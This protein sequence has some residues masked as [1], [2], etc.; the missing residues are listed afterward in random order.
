MTVSWGDLASG[1]RFTGSLRSFLRDR[2]TPQEARRILAQRL[3]DREARFLA[4]LRTIYG[5]AASPYRWLLQVAGCEYGDLVGLVGDQGVEGALQELYRR[6]V[7]LTVAEFKGR[8]PAVRGSAMLL[9]DSALLHRPSSKFH[10]PL[11][12]GGSR[13]DPTTIRLDLASARQAAVN[14][15]LEFE[16]HGG[17]AWPKGS[18]ILPGSASIFTLLSHS[19]FGSVAE[20]WFTPVDVADPALHPRYRWSARALRWGSLAAGIALPLPAFVSLDHPLPI[21]RWLQALLRSGATP[22][23]HATASA[24]VRLCQA[25]EGAGVDLEGAA[26]DVGGEP[27]TAARRR[28]VERVGVRAITRYATVECGPI[29]YGCLAAEESDDAHVLHDLFA[30]VHPP[31]DATARDGLPPR[32]LL[33]TALSEH[34]LL[35]LLNVSLGDVG[36]LVERNCGCPLHQLG[37]TTHL[38]TIRSYEKLTGGGMTF[39]G[40]DVIVV[41]EEKLP[42]RF[43]G[44]PTD[45]QLV[46]EERSDGEPRIR[47]LVHPRLGVLDEGEI[48]RVFLEEIGHGSGAERVMGSLWREAG[49]LSV[50]RQ[51]PQTNYAGK[52]LHLSAGEGYR[53]DP[54]P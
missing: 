27:V 22:Y 34:P 32:A 31:A 45:Y 10:V 25:A 12:S 49:F 9:V 52:V 5:H 28:V 51:K 13:G 11:R 1:I 33:L 16:A 37:W 24:A 18:W 30:M 44:G 6:G 4:T 46:E 38:H 41:L 19:L 39:L 54:S 48:G 2:I 35:M 3:Q 47:L 17:M 26:F 15:C 43:G 20:R 14:R 50:E 42:A 36:T 29:A 7:Y 23:L 53:A 40:V 21:A 8:Q